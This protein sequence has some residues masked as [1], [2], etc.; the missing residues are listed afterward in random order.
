MG[1]GGGGA[2]EKS[3][4]RNAPVVAAGPPETNDTCRRVAAEGTTTW[5]TR[6][7]RVAVQGCRAVRQSQMV[8]NSRLGSVTVDPRS[9]EV[10]LDG[11]RLHLDAVSE[12]P[13]QRLFF[14]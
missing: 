12:I 13:L 8:R 4:I 5:L 2:I 6:R 11:E 1:G 10:R 9:A 3:S 7:R 14:L